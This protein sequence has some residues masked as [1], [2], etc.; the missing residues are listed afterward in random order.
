MKARNECFPFSPCTPLIRGKTLKKRFKR[1]AFK[2]LGG[3]KSIEIQI[4]EGESE[5]V[6]FT[7]YENKI[8]ICVKSFVTRY[9]C[10]DQN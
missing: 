4:R 7:N 9:L 2:F 3:S 8:Q 6:L 5:L 10:Q 1:N